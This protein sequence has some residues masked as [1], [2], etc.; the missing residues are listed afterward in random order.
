MKARNRLATVALT[1]VGYIALFELNELLFSAF[2]FST[3]VDW[4]Y[5]PSGLRLAFVLIFGGWGAL[6]IGFATITI[7]LFHYFN[8][9]VF[10]A[11]ITGL[12]SGGSPLLARKICIDTVVSQRFSEENELLRLEIRI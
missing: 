2:S 1:A 4:I 8:G 10:M 3:G 11:V 6:G 7:D 12:I 9:D 5:M